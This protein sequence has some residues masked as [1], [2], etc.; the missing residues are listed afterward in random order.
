MPTYGLTSSGFMRKPLTQIIAD[1]SADWQT[2]FGQTVNVAPQ[3]G[4][5]QIIG[6]MGDRLDD[7]WQL[8]EAVYNARNP[9]AATGVQQD[10][11]SALT[12]TL[13]KG[14]AFSKALRTILIGSSG[15]TV[16][17]GSLVSGGGSSAI[18]A[19]LTS[20]TLT[21]LSAWATGHVYAA[22]SA[23][24]GSNGTDVYYTV[25]GGTSG[26]GSNPLTGAG[27]IADNTVQWIKVGSSPT[28]YAG[29]T[30]TL[31]QVAGAIAAP[32]GTLSAINTPVAGWLG[33]YNPTDAVLGALAESD[34][35]M[36]LRRQLSV[37]VQGTDN[38]SRIVAALLAP[39]TGV[40]YATGYENT[41]D[42]T[43]GAGL[44]PHSIEIVA[45]GGDPLFV[46]TTIYTLKAAG[47]ATYGVGGNY[48]VSDKEGNTHNILFT[49]PAVVDVYLSL[50]LTTNGLFAPVSQS[51]LDGGTLVKQALAAWGALY[52]TNGSTVVASQVKAVPF[53]FNDTDAIAGVVDVTALTLGTA[54]SP[55]GTANLTFNRRQIPT[56]VEANVL[57]NGA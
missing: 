39:G 45:I 8:A 5:G 15:A 33:V 44:P 50:T 12:G 22:G 4:D 40:T 46:A 17:A 19:T 49:V 2:A 13:R 57:V 32:A 1:L 7:L 51:P 35:P 28:P 38:V 20:A 14:A 24:K 11:I 37:G 54:P 29:F 47:I 43:D 36:R 31:C 23:V 9:N 27:T 42:V 21:L 41:S 34:G 53:G 30:D 48:N 55:V 52:L 56:I 10:A 18:F 25:G 26:G 16:N 3:S 6:V